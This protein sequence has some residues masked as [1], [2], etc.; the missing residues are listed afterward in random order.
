MYTRRVVEAC[1]AFSV[2]PVSQR[3]HTEHASRSLARRVPMHDVIH[4]ALFTW[5]LIA[6]RVALTLQIILELF[7]FRGRHFLPL[8]RHGDEEEDEPSET[9]SVDA[10]GA[11]ETR[12]PRRSESKYG[13]T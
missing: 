8:E 2:V 1:S 6:T 13:K 7:E 9:Q 12:T 5:E 10:L 4:T 3:A 11:R